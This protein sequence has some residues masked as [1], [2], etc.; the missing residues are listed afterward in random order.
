MHGGRAANLLSSRHN[1]EPTAPEAPRHMEGGQEL[2]EH[3]HRLGFSATVIESGL[4]T[5][6]SFFGGAKAPA[7]DRMVK[8]CNR[9]VKWVC[10]N[11]CDDWCFVGIGGAVGP[12]GGESECYGRRG[13]PEC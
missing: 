12:A 4:E 1:P 3:L 11:R 13:K 7:L 5:I 9:E 2:V 6:S 8:W 10:G